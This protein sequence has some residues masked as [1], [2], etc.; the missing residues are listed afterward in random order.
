MI[1][2]AKSFALILLFA[3]QAGAWAS[4]DSGLT[5]YR[6]GNYA[7]ALKDLTAAAADG[8]A[9]AEQLLG[10]MYYMGVGVAQDF[11]KALEWHKKAAGS[12]ETESL[13]VIGTM[14]YSGKGVTQD[15]RTAMQWL[16]KAGDRGHIDAQ[17][18][19]GAMYFTGKGV[20]QDYQRSV[21]W[22]RRAAEHGHAEAQRLLGMMHLYGIGGVQK[23]N[24]IAYMLWN[25]SAASGNAEAL[26]LRNSLGKQLSQHQIEEAQQ[27][28]S[29][30]QQNSPLPTKSENGE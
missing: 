21:I 15:Y 8:S 17:Y 25:L 19:L 9:D 13:Y 7:Q 30:W 14:Y 18:I 10:H 6:S 23:D 22:F 5:A 24:V 1:K 12:G 4:Y 11:G 29:S 20:P 16:T 26:D 27:L 28:S 3:V 2:S